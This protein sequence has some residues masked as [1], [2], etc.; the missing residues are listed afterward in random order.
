MTITQIPARDIIVQV[1]DSTPNTW[2]AIA[3]FEN[4]SV[5]PGQNEQVTETTNYDSDGE[6]EGLVM[7]RGASIQL[8]GKLEKDD[9][10]GALDVGQARCEALGALTGFASRGR[11]RFRH[12]DDTLWKVWVAFVTLGEQGGGNNDMTGWSA[13]FTR[14]GASTTASVS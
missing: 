1:E 12:P 10:T 8:Q 6:Y 5:N 3:G 4:A 7:Q 2:L 9:T 13:T 14:S 11:I